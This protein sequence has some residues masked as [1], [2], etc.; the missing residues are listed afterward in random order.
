MFRVADHTEI[1]TWEY[2]AGHRDASET[3]SHRNESV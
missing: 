2:S 3:D 1:S